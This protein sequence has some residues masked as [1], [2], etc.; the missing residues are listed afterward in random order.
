[1]IRSLLVVVLA[2]AWNCAPAE[3]HVSSDVPVV[4]NDQ[5]LVNPASWAVI[6]IGRFTPGRTIKAVLNFS[7]GTG[8]IGAAILDEANLN[9]Y[10]QGLPFRA[11]RVE[12]Q[13]PPITL[14]GATWTYGA[15]YLL[16]DNRHAVL[17]GRQVAFR[18]EYM[19]K[20]DPAAQQQTKEQLE[21]VYASLKEEFAF[22]DFDI[23]VTPCGQP[24]AFSAPDITLCTELIAQLVAKDRTNALVGIFMHELGH[25]LLNIWGMPGYDN[26]DIADEFAAA[27]LLS[28]DKSDVGGQVLSDMI[29]WFS[30]HDSKAQAVAILAEGDRHAPSIQRVR[31]L[32][33]IMEA[34][35]SVIARWNRMLYQHMTPKALERIASK[36]GA[37][38]DPQLARQI[39]AVMKPVA[40]KAE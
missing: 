12:R 37:H 13:L 14:E 30:E 39:L 33:R 10:R 40:G 26:E 7:G 32:E 19:D 4:V 5:V 29:T 21:K 8:D 27:V 35:A 18:I 2:L 20:V 28:D 24:N 36:P 23:H 6:E 15:Y 34:P 3:V 16:L 9:F 17:A 22:P 31:N 11:H 38:D 1:M 25:T